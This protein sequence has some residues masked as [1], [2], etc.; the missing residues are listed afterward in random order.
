MCRRPESAAAVSVGRARPLDCHNQKIAVYHALLTN[1]YLT[2]RVIPLI[3]VAAVALCVA[4]VIIVVSVM[5]G[6]LNMV[7]SSGRTLMGDVV[8]S[9]STSGIPY[10]Q[11]LIDRIQQLPEAAAATPVVDG[12]GLL[13]MPYPEGPDKHVEQIQFWGIE[14]ISFAAV[15]G[16][17]NSLYWKSVDHDQWLR[18][19][20]DVLTR[21]WKDVLAGMNEDQR[22]DF[23]NAMLKL[24]GPDNYTPPP[25]ELIR[26]R[27]GSMDDEAWDDFFTAARTEPDVLKGVLT[28][29]QWQSLLQHDARLLSP[30]RV[31]QEG[32]TLRHGDNDRTIV[33]GMHVSEGNV[34]QRD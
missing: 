6:F 5:T 1:R 15:T 33:L 13:R 12:V 21:H 29:E 26:E 11:R 7:K 27:M 32:L 16:Y 23:V 2:S 9:Y 4:L 22:I 19:Y 8:V 25:R 18:L 20:V 14:P 3:A 31:L 28:A 24:D 34:R 30:D 10:Y 17:Q